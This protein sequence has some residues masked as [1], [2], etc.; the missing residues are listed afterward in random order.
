MSKTKKQLPIYISALKN[1][2]V[3][4]CSALFAALSIILGKYLAIN[5]GN[6]LR[7]SFE[8]LPIIISGIVFGP[9]VGAIVGIVADLLG[10][11]L[12]GY[13]INPILTL[14]A[15]L[16]GILSGCIS[17]IFKRSPLALR[18]ALAVAVSHIIGSVIVKTIGLASW[19]E[20]SL[21]ILMLWRTL[22]YLIVGTIEYFLIY[23]LLKN[24][25]VSAQ[26]NAVLYN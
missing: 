13:A 14:G 2:K 8:N 20:M 12:V 7:F 16:I 10:C 21:P 9:I 6:V 4:A 17:I 26:I 5:V 18:L 24:K 23:T 15:A 11:V 19:Y 25:T 3:I 1:I 22:T